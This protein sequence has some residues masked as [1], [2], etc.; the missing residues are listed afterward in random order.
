ML[1]RAHLAVLAA[2]VIF[3]TGGAAIKACQ[4]TSWQVAGF[5]SGIAGLVLVLLV[6]PVRQV[7]APILLVALAYAATLVSFVVANKL[8]TAAHA[9]FLQAAAPVYVILL[10]RVLLGTRLTRH[11]LPI[12]ALVIAGLALLF[13]DAGPAAATAPDPARGNLVAVSSGLFYALMLVGLRWLA[14]RTH[15]PGAA[16]AAALWGN[17]LAFAL[18]LPL[19]TPIAGARP[20]DWVVLAY[21][22]A[23]QIA[24]AYYLLT[25]AVR[26]VS[27]LDVSLLLLLEPVLNPLWAWWLQ[28]ER[29]GRWAALGGAL[30]LGATAWRSLSSRPPP[31]GV[32]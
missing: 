1:T 28:G 19:A 25:R 14:S 17:L 11:D 6:A 22:G 30:V 32:P 20:L 8:T 10:E 4:L 3:S 31:A 7:S 27:A 15:R 5:R 26:T 24:L 16:S 21:L 13:S 29:P 12:A 2:A 18:C 23:V 9:V